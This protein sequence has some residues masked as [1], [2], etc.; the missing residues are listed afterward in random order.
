MVLN[1]K[2]SRVPSPAQVEEFK[3]LGVFLTKEGQVEREIDR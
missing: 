2:K 3:Q 1:Q